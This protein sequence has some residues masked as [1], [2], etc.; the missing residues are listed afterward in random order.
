MYLL[1]KNYLNNFLSLIV[2]LFCITTATTAQIN[3]QQTN[4]PCGATVYAL[5]I[6]G[7][8]LF[9]ATRGNIYLSTNNG[10]SWNA[11]S[12]SLGNY[13]FTSIVVSGANI[14]VGSLGGGVFLS[15]DNGLSWTQVNNGLTELGVTALAVS[16][17]NLFAG[18]IGSGIFL[19]TNNGA[20]WSEVNNGLTKKWVTAFAV[21]GTDLFAR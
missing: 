9:A 14:F 1:R 12:T 3:W 2:L 17:T 19:S 6:S 20:S 18:T 7:T 5:E 4:G 15:N 13:N 11:I 10:S 21:S 16:G 8:N